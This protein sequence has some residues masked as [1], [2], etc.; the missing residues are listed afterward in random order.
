MLDRNS[1]TWITLRSRI[2]ERIEK[3][4]TDIEQPGFPPDVARGEIAGLRWAISQV[5]PDA[6]IREPTSTDYMRSFDPS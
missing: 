2:C 6:P 4:R 1:A 3:L 5:E